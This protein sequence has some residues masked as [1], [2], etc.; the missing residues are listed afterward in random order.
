MAIGVALVLIG[1]LLIVGAS[2]LSRVVAAPNEK[3]GARAPSNLSFTLVGVGLVIVGLA[4][5][6]GWI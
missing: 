5:L 1:G 3:L 2:K 6:A 4:S